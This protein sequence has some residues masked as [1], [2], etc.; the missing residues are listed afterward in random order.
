M[1][2]KAGQ[3][4]GIFSLLVPPTKINE[5]LI[6]L[7]RETSPVSFHATISSQ[8]GGGLTLKHTACFSKLTWEDSFSSWTLSE[9]AVWIDL[10]PKN[11]Q[12]KVSPHELCMLT[13]W[14]S[15]MLLHESLIHTPIPFHQKTEIGYQWF[16]CATIIKDRYFVL[17]VMRKSV[18][19]TISR[20]CCVW[21]YNEIGAEITKPISLKENAAPKD[22]NSVHTTN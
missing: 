22:I 3:C 6:L 17:G 4:P 9:L 7:S 13:F 18:S 20:I 21:A 2:Q 15:L 5:S 19:G 14:I 10:L 8:L 12:R 16:T 11:H 1:A